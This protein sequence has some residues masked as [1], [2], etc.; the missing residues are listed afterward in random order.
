[1]NCDRK[2]KRW[3][4]DTVESSTLMTSGRTI[5]R[6][7]IHELIFKT[8][9]VVGKIHGVRLTAVC[10]FSSI[11]EHERRADVAQSTSLPT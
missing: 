10:G 5:V 2:K 3:G 11:L 9:V 7:K 4:N 8:P 1:M 6:K